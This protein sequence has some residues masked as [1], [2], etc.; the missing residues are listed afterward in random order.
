MSHSLLDLSSLP[1]RSF[2]CRYQSGDLCESLCGIYYLQIWPLQTI[3][4][5]TLQLPSPSLR[6]ADTEGNENCAIVHKS[7]SRTKV[8]GVASVPST[9]TVYFLL[10]VVSQW[11]SVNTLS[12]HRRVSHS[13]LLVEH[14]LSIL[15]LPSLRAVEQTRIASLPAS[16]HST[17]RSERI[18]SLVRIQSGIDECKQGQGANDKI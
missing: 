15:S 8:F 17:A 4:G 5:A 18:A 12:A 14:D 16:L 10:R 11:A 7:Y 3:L 1:L 13:V 6:L 9:C 2:L